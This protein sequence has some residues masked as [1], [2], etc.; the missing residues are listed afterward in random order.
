MG[1]DINDSLLHTRND[2]K[3]GSVVGTST[4]NNTKRQS[5]LKVRHGEH[6]GD[7]DDHFN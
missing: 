4:G 2:D 3:F 5:V 6:V 1:Q 7:S